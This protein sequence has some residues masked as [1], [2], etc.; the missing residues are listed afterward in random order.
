LSPFYRDDASNVFDG[1]VQGT[2]LTVT[3]VYGTTLYAEVS[4]I[5]NAE[6]QG[7]FSASSAGVLLLDPNSIPRILSLTNDNLLTWSSVSNNI[8]QV[9]ATTNLAAGFIS[10]SGVI[11]ATGPTSL[12]LDIGAT[13][14]QMFYRVEMVP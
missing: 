14:S 5:N 9:M 12:Y 3:N 6:I 13:N 7:P 1:I 11:T 4:A 10:I 2:T 8:Y